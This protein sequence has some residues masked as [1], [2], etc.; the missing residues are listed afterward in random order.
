MKRTLAITDHNFLYQFGNSGDS[1]HWEWRPPP[2]RHGATVEV[3]WVWVGF[4]IFFPFSNQQTGRW[5]SWCAQQPNVGLHA[6]KETNY[7]YQKYLTIEP[8][9]SIVMKK[10]HT[11]VLWQYSLWSF[12]GR[13]T[14]LER[15][16]AQN[17]L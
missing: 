2:R 8:I 16:L 9:T 14:K 3:G 6:I 13:D 17:H 7:Y 15:F 1:V 5:S 4:L 12:Q 10:G 11:L